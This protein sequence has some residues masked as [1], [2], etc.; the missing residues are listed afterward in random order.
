MSSNKQIE[1]ALQA[2]APRLGI[3]AI[4]FCK[5]DLEAST[6]FYEEWLRAGFG[7]EMGY[8]HT[9]LELKSRI[10]HVLPGANSAIAIRVGYNQP[11][12]LTTLPRIARYAIGR[13]YHKVLRSGMKKLVTRAQQLEPKAS[14]RIC[15]D[16]A[17]VFERAIAQQ[18][19]L[20]WFG[21][22]SCLIDSKFGS[23]FFLGVILTDL[24]LEPSRPAKGGCGTCHLCIDACPTGAIVKLK[25]RWVVDSRDCISYLTIEK[26][27]EFT[28]EQGKKLNE[29]IFGCDVCQEVCPFN[30]PRPDQPLRATFTGIEDFKRGRPTPSTQEAEAFTEGEWDAWSNGRAV[31][32]MGYAGF[33][34]NM[35]AI[36]QAEAE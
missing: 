4:G 14:F 5:P 28:K 6:R 27:G 15:V 29:W 21:K 22:N 35:K 34:R 9:H 32:R 25:D 24:E 11:V 31:R 13:D 16:S 17:P 30:Q 33:N 23:W 26:K 10:D 1:D 20:G 12:D 3:D 18:A 7:A 19:G 36:R 8:L 2:L